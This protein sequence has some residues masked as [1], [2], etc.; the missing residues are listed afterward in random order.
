M[1][2][3]SAIIV[4]AIVGAFTFWVVKQ[5]SPDNKSKSKHSHRH[6]H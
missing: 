4:A 2:I 3:F 6:A 5:G 1:Y